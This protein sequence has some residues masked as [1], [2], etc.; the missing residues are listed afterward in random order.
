M[1]NN[2][3][4][5]NCSEVLLEENLVILTFT[6]VTFIVDQ[7]NAKNAYGICWDL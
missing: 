2:T 6:L 5:F 3:E 1:D 4:S 7:F